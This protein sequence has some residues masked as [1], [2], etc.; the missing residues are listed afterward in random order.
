MGKSLDVRKVD[1]WVIVE[2]PNFNPHYF[3]TFEEA[4]NSPIRG[5]LMT[6]KFYKQ[7]YEN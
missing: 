5:H 2:I 3:D 4:L 6:N 1:T 7:S